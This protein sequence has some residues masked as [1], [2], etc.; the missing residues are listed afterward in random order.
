MFP[1]A[2]LAALLTRE[3]VHRS[4]RM[5][6]VEISSYGCRFVAGDGAWAVGG[7]LARALFDLPHEAAD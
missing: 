2:E 4:V 1:E 5:H 7:R 3:D 6:V